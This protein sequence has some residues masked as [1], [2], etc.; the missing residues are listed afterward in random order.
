MLPTG[1]LD[2]SAI[3]YASAFMATPKK[4][5]QD[6]T[7]NNFEDSEIYRSSDDSQE[8]DTSDESL[9]GSKDI[10][11]LSSEEDSDCDFRLSCSICEMKQRTRMHTKSS[12]SH[13]RS[14]NKKG[15][16]IVQTESKKERDEAKA[17]FVNALNQVAC[18]VMHEGSANHSPTH[19][20]GRVVSALFLMTTRPYGPWFDSPRRVILSD[21]VCLGD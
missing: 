15:S 20:S 12:E 3:S 16:Y 21:C 10:S 11:E 7:S 4:K 8:T 18:T 2:D 5:N 19:V 9:I 6:Y 13:C 14:Q 1:P 17:R